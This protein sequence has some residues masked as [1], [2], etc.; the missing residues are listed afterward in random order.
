VRGGEG[1]GEVGRDRDVLRDREQWGRTGRGGE[2]QR[3]VARDRERCG[4]TGSSGE[5]Q[6]AVGRGREQW[7]GAGIFLLFRVGRDRR[8]IPAL[9]L[10]PLG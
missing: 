10:P 8:H 1:E 7:G 2:G 3:A 6:G 4:G 5:G 9:P